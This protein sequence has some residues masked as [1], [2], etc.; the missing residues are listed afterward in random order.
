MAGNFGREFTWLIGGI[1]SNPPKFPLA[2][3][4]QYDVIIAYMLLCD[5][6]NM[7]SP[8]FK[9]STQNLQTLKECN[10]NSPDLVYH[11]LAPVRFDLIWFEAD[12]AVLTLLTTL[13]CDTV[14]ILV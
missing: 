9:M 14:T 10:E 7:W 5:V 3:Y 2:K 11:Q 6:I 12:P 4:L 13:V 8:P 1:E